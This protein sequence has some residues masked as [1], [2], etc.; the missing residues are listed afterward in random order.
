MLSQKQKDFISYWEK[1]RDLQSTAQHKLIS[2][3]PVAGLY[4]LPILLSLVAVYLFAPEWYTRVSK[5]QPG[6]VTAIVIAVLL[7]I[8]LFA[9]IRSHFKW[10]QKEQFY[11]EL[12]AKQNQSGNAE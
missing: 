10:E 2:G 4:G 8:V 5:M 7:F 11:R 1:Q 9:F 6:T 3:L 12:L